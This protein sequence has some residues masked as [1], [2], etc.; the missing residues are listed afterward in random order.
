[1][2]TLE[3]AIAARDEF[4]KN[5]PD[6]QA[7]QDEIDDILSKTSEDKRL[8]V[9][10]LLMATKTVELGNEVAKLQ[11]ILVGVANDAS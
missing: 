6:M 11:Q 2:P 5:N 4:L 10:A 8:E 1:M 7:Y 3:E 9:M